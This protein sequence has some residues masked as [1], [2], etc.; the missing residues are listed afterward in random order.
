MPG[1]PTYLDNSRARAYFCLQLVQMGRFGHFFAPL[2]FLFSFSLSKRRFD[3]DLT[4]QPYL[5]QCV[6]NK[7]AGSQKDRL[8]IIQLSVVAYTNS[9]F[10]NAENA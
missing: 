6:H 3:T 5:L 10:C 9:I 2:Y 4:N 8:K 7:C 1:R